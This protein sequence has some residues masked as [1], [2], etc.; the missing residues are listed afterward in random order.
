MISFY[1]DANVTR[2]GATS[3][4]GESF[5]AVLETVYRIFCIKFF[6]STSLRR[7]PGTDDKISELGNDGRLFSVSF[8]LIKQMHIYIKIV[9]HAALRYEK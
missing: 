3:K 6:S 2:K 5:A 1:K 9:P 8:R 7:F 4:T